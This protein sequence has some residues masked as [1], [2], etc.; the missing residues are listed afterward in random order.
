MPTFNLAEWFAQLVK[1]PTVNRI[2]ES[3]EKLENH[4]IAVARS[5]SELSKVAS[6]VH[7]WMHDQVNATATT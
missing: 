7:Q 2:Y 4:L 1:E 3:L 5:W 6:L